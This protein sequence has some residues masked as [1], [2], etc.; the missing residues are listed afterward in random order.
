[1]KE[2][3]SIDSKRN[4]AGHAE[5]GTKEDGAILEMVKVGKRLIIIKDNSIY[6]F[7]MADSIDPGRKNINLP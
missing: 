3:N 5:I 7:F 4:S 2:D 6:E 1:M